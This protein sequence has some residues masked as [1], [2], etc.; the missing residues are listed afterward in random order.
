MTITTGSARLKA[1][2]LGVVRDVA[3]RVGV[4]LLIFLKCHA[5]YLED[6]NIHGYI[7]VLCIFKHLFSA[8][9]F[10][11]LLDSRILYRTL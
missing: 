3:S 9:T 2:F 7:K 6:L 8:A 10:R 5:I 11:P 4:A 1:V